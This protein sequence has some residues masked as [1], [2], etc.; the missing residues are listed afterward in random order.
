MSE[1]PVAYRPDYEALLKAY[2]GEVAHTRGVEVSTGVYLERVHESR[3]LYSVHIDSQWID[4]VDAAQF[5][6]LRDFD[7]EIRLIEA[8]ARGKVEEPEDHDEGRRVGGFQ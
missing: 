5:P 3:P 4:A 7:N 1:Q 8:H 6:A 2:T